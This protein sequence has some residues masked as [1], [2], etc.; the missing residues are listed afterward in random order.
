MSA[1]HPIPPRRQ[2]DTAQTA[3]EA[4]IPPGRWWGNHPAEL[5]WLAE[6][7]RMTLDQVWLGGGIPHGDGR[8][9]VLIPGFGAG[10]QTLAVL[11][12]W[13]WRI[14]YRPR[15]CGFVLNT[16]C[17]ERALERV[18][19]GV[20]ALHRRTGR[21]IAV[22]GHSRGGHLARA[23]AARRPELVSHAVSLGADLQ[24]M[25]HC[26]APTLAAVEA[27]RWVLRRSERARSPECLTNHC[28]CSFATAFWAPFPVDRVRLTSIYSRG[29]GVVRWQTQRVP[30]A[31]CVE[32]NSSHVG[33]IL[34]RNSYR[35]IATALATPEL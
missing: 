19:R 20:V 15:P 33:L 5:R 23:I 22:I 3:G 34:N 31:N 25:F 6:A 26:S 11:A 27:A 12:S 7:A 9:V 24:A 28:R 16:D 30:Y 1:A 10:D 13:L 18:E 2:P 32:V 14:G 29:D 8:G 35:A 21:R 4:P 17:S